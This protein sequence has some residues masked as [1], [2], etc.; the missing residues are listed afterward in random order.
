MAR[1]VPKIYTSIK[2]ISTG[3]VVKNG[4]DVAHNTFPTSTLVHYSVPSLYSP[5]ITTVTDMK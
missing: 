1:E 4:R 2:L 5:V 3:E